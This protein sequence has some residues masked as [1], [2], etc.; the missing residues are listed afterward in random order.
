MV[1]NGTEASS[2]SSSSGVRSSSSA[3][4]PDS[5]S[6][7]YASTDLASSNK[8]IK[9]HPSG[10][11]SHQAR[12]AVKGPEPSEQSES[13]EESVA[14]SDKQSLIETKNSAIKFSSASA[15]LGHALQTASNMCSPSEEPVPHPSAVVNTCGQCKQVLPSTCPEIEN[16]CENGVRE[17]GGSLD[18]YYAGSCSEDCYSYSGSVCSCMGSCDQPQT[19]NA[20]FGCDDSFNPVHPRNCC[21]GGCVGGRL[22]GSNGDSNGHPLSSHPHHHAAGAAQAHCSNSAAVGNNFEMAVGANFERVRQCRSNEVDDVLD[23]EETIPL[24]MCQDIPDVLI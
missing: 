18:H 4:K 23:S 11:S 24:E 3:S 19:A 9:T 13:E 12:V 7:G 8:P 5:S 17:R 1:A 10:V 6:S 22:A 16:D 20:H 15:V 2:T 21:D 14:V